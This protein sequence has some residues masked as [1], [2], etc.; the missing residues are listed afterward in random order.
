M[1]ICGKKIHW[2]CRIWT[3]DL[4]FTSPML[5]QPSYWV[6]WGR[7]VISLSAGLQFNPVPPT[8]LSGLDKYKNILLKLYHKHMCDLLWGSSCMDKCL[9][10]HETG[11]N[12]KSN[13]IIHTPLC[14]F[15]WKGK[16][17]QI[18][19]GGRRSKIMSFCPHFILIRTLRSPITCPIDASY[20]RRWNQWFYEHTKVYT[21]TLLYLAH[22]P[23][24]RHWFEYTQW[25]LGQC[26]VQVVK[27]YA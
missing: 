6:R 9:I 5:Y 8:S 11:I 2:P 27:W 21:V 20:S 18:K 16:E 12:T 25:Y 4:R 26:Q 10:L 13:L 17:K 1:T 22:V 15:L 23:L 24:Y 7:A 3:W 14:V 19:G